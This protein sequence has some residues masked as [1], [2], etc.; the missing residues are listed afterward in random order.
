MAR[1]GT[2]VPIAVHD[3]VEAFLSSSFTLRPPKKTETSL[4]LFWGVRVDYVLEGE[5]VS[6]WICL[7]S[8]ACRRANKFFP[9]YSGKTSNATKHLKDPHDVSSK[10]TVALFDRKRSREEEFE[11]LKN[12]D[13]FKENPQ[14][15]KLLLETLRIVFNNLPF[16][17]GEYEEFILI[18]NVIVDK[19]ARTPVHAKAVTRSIVELYASTRQEIVGFLEENRV[20]NAN[21]FTMVMDFWTCKTKKMTFLGLRVHFVDTEWN[22]GFILIGTRQFSSEYGD[23]DGGIRGPFQTWINLILRA[24]GLSTA[25]FFG[26]TTD[27]G[28]GVKYMMRTGQSLQ[29]EWCIPHLT[30]ASTKMACDM[31]AD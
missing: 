2:R 25:D 16:R 21:S 20:H 14:R 23:R 17:V 28:A 5:P 13:I 11:R 26:A 31:V 1:S 24:F 8:D 27:G 4:I 7:G 18:E 6:G 10:K 19:E 12:S 30:N 22:F 9:L 29:W 15:L 3:A